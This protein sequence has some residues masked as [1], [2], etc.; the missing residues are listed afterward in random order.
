[1]QKMAQFDKNHTSDQ[2]KM[3]YVIIKNVYYI[4]LC[5]SYHSPVDLTNDGQSQ[6]VC[7]NRLDCRYLLNQAEILYILIFH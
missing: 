2:V 1:M 4:V 7:L 6:Y 3:G 5:K